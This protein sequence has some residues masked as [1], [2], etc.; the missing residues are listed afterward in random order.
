MTDTPPV[1]CSRTVYDHLATAHAAVRCGG[2]TVVIG[3]TD[4]ALY[5]SKRVLPYLP[6]RF[7]E[8]ADPPVHLHLGIY[9]YRK[10]A[11]AAYAALPPCELEELEGLEQLRFLDAGAKV[12][13]V[14]IDRLD[15]D[16]IE[17]NNPSDTPI[18]EAILKDRGIA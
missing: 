14:R 10:S 2:T 3:K 5:F 16:S 18:I 1:P 6:A 9:A 7:A 8:A 11:L 17:L 13:V 15:W 4:R 12:R